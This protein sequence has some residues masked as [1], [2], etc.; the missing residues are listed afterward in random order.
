VQFTS[1]L[2]LNGNLQQFAPSSP[3]SGMN[4]FARQ[5]LDMRNSY[6]QKRIVSGSDS[7]QRNKNKFLRIPSA[8]VGGGRWAPGVFAP[9]FF[10]AGI[11]EHVSASFDSVL[12]AFTF[13]SKF[14]KDP[15]SRSS[16]PSVTGLAP[17]HFDHFSFRD[18]WPERHR[19]YLPNSHDPNF[20][21]TEWIW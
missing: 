6:P 17:S 3:L 7:H 12:D 4:E 13:I 8:H 9:R 1:S 19:C 18:Q 20:Q 15:G 11:H 21:T 5:W 10:T 16:L 14:E 2:G